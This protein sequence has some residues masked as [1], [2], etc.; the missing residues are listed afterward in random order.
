MLRFTFLVLS[1]FVVACGSGD[2]IDPGDGGDGGGTEASSAPDVHAPA[3]PSCKAG[4]REEW[5]GTIPNTVI[6]VAVCS[7]CGESYVV[8]SNGNT[9]P[10]DVT[11]DNG[12]K[13]LTT[14]IP[15]GAT[16]TSATLADKPSDGTITVCSGKNCL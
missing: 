14:T 8:A 11:M 5:S 4:D 6:A 10:G 9:S 15:A 13:T 16:A 12:T 2:G 3:A 7:T 1:S